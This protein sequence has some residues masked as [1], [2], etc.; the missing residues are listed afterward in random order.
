MSKS[1]I[2]WQILWWMR[3]IPQ[4]ILFVLFILG[5][6][7]LGN[8][9]FGL[10]SLFLGAYLYF[11]YLFLIRVTLTRFHMQ[12]MRFVRRRRFPEAIEQFQQGYAFFSKYLWLDRFRYLTLLSASG[13]SFRELALLNIAYCYSEMGD[14][15]QVKSCY[16][17]ILT[18][19]PNNSMAQSSLNF[20]H[21]VEKTHTEQ[22]GS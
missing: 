13:L 4:F 12:G 18:E 9:E 16:E 19:F 3:R 1:S 2:P 17:R 8:V 22:G 15:P 20:I 5:I 21:A 10:I 11:A 14:V 6:M 7:A